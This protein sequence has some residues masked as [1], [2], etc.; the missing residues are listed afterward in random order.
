MT[1]T[2][3]GQRQI[4]TKVGRLPP[5]VGLYRTLRSQD[6]YHKPWVCSTISQRDLSTTRGHATASHR[7]QIALESA[8]RQPLARHASD[9][10]RALAHLGD[11]GRSG[12]LHGHAQLRQELVQEGAYRLQ[13]LARRFEEREAH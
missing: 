13:P 5:R 6:T 10:D 8:R 9:D 7:M 11:G 4:S 2:Q 1:P 3:R 12:Q